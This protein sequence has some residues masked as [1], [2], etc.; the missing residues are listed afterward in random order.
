MRSRLRSTQQLRNRPH[1]PVR[2][3]RRVRRQPRAG[4]VYPHRMHPEAMWRGDVRLQA[5][6]HHPHGR[7]LARDSIER[8]TEDAL[9]RLSAAELALDHDAVE[10]PREVVL[11]DAPAL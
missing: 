2:L 5:V 4:R 10:V 11:L 8:V 3:H 6:A 7:W 9:V 1:H